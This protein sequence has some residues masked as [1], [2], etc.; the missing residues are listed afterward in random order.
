MEKQTKKTG[1]S[2]VTLLILTAIVIVAMSFF[3]NKNNT[4]TQNNSILS[5]SAS[6]TTYEVLKIVDGDTIKINYQGKIETIRLIGIDTPEL[7]DNR[8]QVECYANEASQHLTDILKNQSIILEADSTQGET[9]RYGRLLAYIFLKDGTN[10]NQKMLA[11]GFAYEFTYDE[12][13]K[14]QEEFKAAEK[15]AKTQ[16]LGL[17][18]DTTCKGER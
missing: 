17:W 15:N 8:D 13:Y 12:P 10:I 2:F 9:D 11:D 6:G 14:Y 4:T 18:A 1:S 5:Q 16:K 3:N 7:K